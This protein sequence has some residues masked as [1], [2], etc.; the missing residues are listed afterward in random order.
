MTLTRLAAVITALAAI[1]LALATLVGAIRVDLGPIAAVWSVPAFV[2]A[3]LFGFVFGFHIGRVVLR[4]G[5]PEANAW[6]VGTLGAIFVSGL[7]LSQVFA[8]ILT[9]DEL[10]ERILSRL[11]PYLAGSV[12][13][14]AGVFAAL[15][16]RR[17]SGE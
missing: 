3:A 8:A 7:V 10:V 14:G 17:E 11:G 2:F 13:M 1:A 9:G 15:Y 12:A 16:L 5:D 4:N 6:V